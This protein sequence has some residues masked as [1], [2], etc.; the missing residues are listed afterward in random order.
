MALMIT[1]IRNPSHRGLN[2]HHHDQSIWYVSF[3]V[4]KIN[5]RAVPLP[6]LE[7][8]VDSVAMGEMD[9]FFVN[10]FR[11]TFLFS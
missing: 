3:R 9:Y 5:K 11:L 1:S 6:I 8:F 7:L 2:T 4:I 10:F